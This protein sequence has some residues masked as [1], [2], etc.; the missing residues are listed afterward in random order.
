MLGTVVSIMAGLTLTVMQEFD[1]FSRESVA[2]LSQLG[3][4]TSLTADSALRKSYDEFIASIRT[5]NDA[6]SSIFRRLARER[7]TSLNSEFRNIAGQRLDYLGTEAWRSA[8]AAV[9]KESALTEYCSVAW[10]RT[11]NYWQDQPG[12]QSL[13]INC[14]L[15]ESGVAVTRIIIQRSHSI[16]QPEVSMQITDR[17]FKQHK[18]GIR[19]LCIDEQALVGEDD[20][21]DDFGIYGSIAVGILAT[22]DTSSRTI[23]FR[24]SFDPLDVKLYRDKW[25][26]LMLYATDWSPSE[27]KL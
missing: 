6:H 17:M 25:K 12:L 14:E 16:D 1:R 22:D 21:L 26:R 20:L 7:L 13:R 5:I 8:Y 15:A 19:L 11:G 18:A 23:Q 3:M 27:A 4:V 2:A 10:V 9:L 24:L